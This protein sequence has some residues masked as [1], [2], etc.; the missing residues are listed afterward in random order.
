[1]SFRRSLLV[2]VGLLA[3]G[4]AVA[5]PV[6]VAD[7][8]PAACGVTDL[9]IKAS[10]YWVTTSA[11][12]AANNWS[13]ASFHVG[14]LAQVRT[15]G[16]SNHKTWPWT[17][18]NQWLLPTDTAHPFAADAQASGEA[19]L[20]V[21]FFHQENRV[22]DPLRANLAAE[23]ASVAEGHTRYWSTPDAINF[24][25]PSFTRIGLMDGKPE[26]LDASRTLFRDAKRRMFSDLTGLWLGNAQANGFAATGLAKA[27]LALP[28]DSPFRAEYARTLKRQAE[29]LRWLQRP[30][31][32]WN[33]E[34]V[35]G[36]KEASSTALITYALAAG[37][38]AGVLDAAVYTPIVQKGWTALTTGALQSSG[39][40]GYVQP[41]GSHQ[42][43]GVADTAAFGVGALLIAGQQVA[44]LT[45]GC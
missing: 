37:V 38:N 13:N 39:A 40:L 20:D 43:A 24:S 6:A 16:I 2:V 33:A 31:G 12:H 26:L 29:A 7:P 34:L 3:G 19:Y 32:F 42:Q 21:W 10:S 36:G 5:T 15:T 44:K 22:L 14:N 45:P 18:A 35:L 4:L 27:V 28:A 9:M 23:A 30:D 17:Q 8:A 1:M 25:L 41:R 11:D